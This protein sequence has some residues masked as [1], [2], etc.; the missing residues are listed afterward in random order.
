MHQ[1]SCTSLSATDGTT[2]VEL[3]F[4]YPEPGYLVTK[5]VAVER[6]SGQ[7]AWLS[8]HLL[9]ASELGLFEVQGLLDRDRLQQ[10]LVV[11]HPPLSPT[12]TLTV[13]LANIPDV[14]AD[15]NSLEVSAHPETS[16]LTLYLVVAVPAISWLF[17]TFVIVLLALRLWRWHTSHLFHALGVGLAGALSSHFVCMDRVL[18]FLPTYSQEASFMVDSWESHVIFPQPKYDN[19]LISQRAGRKMTFYMFQMILS[20]L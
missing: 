13:T 1:R 3:T 16:D 7:N 8:Y 2:S 10:N 20:F 11:G 15:F 17:L 4:Q 18:A 5:V 9:K 12:I 6:D 19:M 14:L